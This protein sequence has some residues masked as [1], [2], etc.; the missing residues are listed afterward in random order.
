MRKRLL[1]LA[2]V[3]LTAF[4]LP[5]QGGETD[6]TP[7]ATMAL[8]MGVMSTETA[9]VGTGIAGGIEFAVD[10]PLIRLPYGKI[11]DQFS[12]NRFERDWLTLQTIEF[13]PHYMVPLADNFWVGAGP[14]VGWAFVHSDRGNSPDMWTVQAGVSAYYTLDKVMVGLESRYQW[15]ADE[16]VGNAANG[17]NWMTTL[18]LGY[19]F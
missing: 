9:S 8:K 19:A 16:R 17:D 14:G 11:R 6:Y 13:N 10:D 18:K 12:Y 4:A 3:A 1:L 7:N 2:A 5:A 15:T